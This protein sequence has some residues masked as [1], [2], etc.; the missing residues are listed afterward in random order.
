M[1]TLSL[2]SDIIYQVQ[3]NYLDGS[4]EKVELDFDTIQEL[5][6]V[7]NIPISRRFY[8][9]KFFNPD[10]STYTPAVFLSFEE[11]AGFITRPDG[12]RIDFVILSY[13]DRLIP[14][15]PN[16]VSPYTPEQPLPP[17]PPE[18]E[19][20]PYNDPIGLPDEPNPQDFFPADI[21]KLAFT[22]VEYVETSKGKSL[23]AQIQVTRIKKDFDVRNVDLFLKIENA[24]GIQEVLSKNMSIGGS[25]KF[26]TSFNIDDVPQA[27]VDIKITA[28]MWSYGVPVSQ[29]IT[30]NV[31]INQKPPVTGGGSST[32]PN[33]FAKILGITA[34][35]GTTMFI[36]KESSKLGKKNGK[37]KKK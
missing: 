30:M 32:S 14:K 23:F 5:I 20:P 25:D 12:S 31:K 35:I 6:N 27:T 34:A 3:I 36:A 4:K 28:F 8:K 29:S 33:L 9:I 11:I 18:I 22:A 2:N 7:F 19:I 37:K 21:Y 16:Y 17:L 10:G 24:F 1:K 15:D 13:E 26:G